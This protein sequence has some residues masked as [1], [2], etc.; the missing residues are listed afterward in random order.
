MNGLSA[1][2]ALECRGTVTV[3]EQS[4]FDG[5]MIR[6]TFE[7]TTGTIT[8]I[9]LLVI[10]LLTS[11]LSV[12]AQE[13]LPSCLSTSGETAVIACRRELNLAPHNLNIRFALSDALLSL[14]RHKEAV[15]VLKEGLERSP[16][17]DRIKKKLSL[18]E[19]YLEEQSWIE[20]RRSQQRDSAGV[21][22]SKR[23]STETKLNIIRCK[24]L[25]GDRALKACNSVLSVLPDDP[26]VHRSKADVLM[27]MGKIVEAVLAYQESLRLAPDDAKT[28]EKLSA[29][30][31]K[32]TAIVT[33]CQ[34]LSGAA[35]LSACD[36]VLLKGAT[37]ES[38]IQKR[39]GDLFLGMKRTEDA[40]KAYQSALELSP[41]DLETKKKLDSLSTPVSIVAVDKSARP[42]RSAIAQ[43]SAEAEASASHNPEEQIVPPQAPV[44]TAK[45]EQSEQNEAEGSSPVHTPSPA[46]LLPTPK[47]YSN[48]P[49]VAGITH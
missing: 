31:S 48:R 24:K 35:A 43:Q 18:T 11:G 20:K 46:P 27:E 32:R 8:S 16:G 37:D 39:R 7:A 15:E 4:R 36:S 19:S 6:R 25:K 45:L 26:S 42:Q 28:S 47:R 30:Q 17:S 44:Q 3:I 12:D 40:K 5:M 10:A 23:L 29:A 9:H 41:D 38:A 2:K 34:R 22:D 1:I 33:E 14:S 49:P 13:H 21:A